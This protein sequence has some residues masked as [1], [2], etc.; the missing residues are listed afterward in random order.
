MGVFHNRF[1]LIVT[2]LLALLVFSG[3]VLDDVWNFAGNAVSASASSNHQKGSAPKSGTATH[4]DT[5]VIGSNLVSLT[6][7]LPSAFVYVSIEEAAP[8][9]LPA[10]IDHPPQLA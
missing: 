5:A 10:S 6:L 9:A 4:D 8:P 2:A 3:D 1:V 7:R